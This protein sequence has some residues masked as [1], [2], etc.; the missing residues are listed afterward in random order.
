MKS[1]GQRDYYAQE[2][3]HHLLSLKLVSSSLKVVPV[4]LNGSRRVKDDLKDGDCVTN[5]S[6][7]DTYAKRERFSQSFSNILSVNFITFATKYKIVNNKLLNQ[8]DN[9]VPRTFPVF[10]SSSSGPNFGLYCKYQLLKYKPWHTKPDNAWNDQ[11]GT[12]EIY[13]N[14]WKAFLETP[15]AKDNVPDWSDKLSSCQN[16]AND[17]SGD[18]VPILEAIEREEWMHLADLIPGLFVDDGTQERCLPNFVWQIDRNN[19]TESEIAEMPSWVKTKKESNSG[20]IQ[21]T[22]V[23]TSTFSDMQRFAYN[24]IE[25]H[26]QQSCAKDPLFL[27]IIGGAGTGK[28]YL[29]HAIRNLL[30]TSCV[31]TATTGKAS[32]NIGGFTIHSLLKLPVGPRGNKDLVGNSLIRLQ[33]NLKD[34]KYILIDEYSMLG[35]TTFGWVDRRCRQA[36]GISD[37]LFGGK[38]IIL[39]GDPGQLP[40]VGDKPL[41]HAK[42]S[43]SIGEQGHSVFLMFTNVVKL[44]VN[45]RVQGGDPEQIQFR[46]L[47]CRLRT[48][49]SNEHDWKILLTRQ[50]S[51]VQN[52]NDF[53][54]ATRLYFSNEEVANYNF[55]QLVGLCQPIARINAFHSSAVA[56]KA[57]ADEMSGLEPVI[58]LAKG[59]RIMLT[60]NLWAEVGLCNGATGTLLEFIYAN[61]HQ[62]PD[63]PVSVIVQ[64]DDYKG[65]S[66]CSNRNKCV[67]ISPITVSSHTLD[68]VH[69]RQQLPLKL[70]WAMT[71]HK[72]Q[73]LTLPKA[74]INVGQTEKTAGI[75]Y[76][77]ISR[78]R[79]LSDCIVE[80]MT[81]ERLTSLKRSVTLKFRLDE[82]NRLENLF[83]STLQKFKM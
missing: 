31:I 52:I 72:S 25:T 56:K 68:G 7:L 82:E 80:P 19:Y 3:M 74:W 22:V 38:S 18:V 28:S 73:G 70:A 58:F 77:A 49:D 24:V 69:E 23:D 34:I 83:E 12:D 50:P 47:L 46:D 44:T 8:S 60:I 67:P 42:P 64:F 48:G 17:N 39:L 54:L 43:S 11:L 63:L 36:T 16:Q 6:L 78:V 26:L 21:Q 79:A 32:Y 30:Q 61:N 29:I 40:P 4:S 66:I 1:F 41:Y 10:S 37:E 33:E 81:F 57:S 71:I 13:I 27:I 5:D 62:P 9:I 45:Q 51:N 75:S 20:V 53:Q 14:S 76:V 2:V 59:A 15:F 65:P 55:E 35:Q